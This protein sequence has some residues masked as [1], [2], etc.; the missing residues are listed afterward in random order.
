MIRV[1]I[2]D[3]SAVL[4][5]STKFILES[6]PELCV[7]GQASNGAEAIT[8]AAMLKPDVI[9]M[10]IRMPKVDGLEAIREIMAEHPTPIVVVTGVDLDRES[11]VSAQAT[12]L[13]AV[14][15]LK[16]PD[17]IASSDYKTF[18]ARLIRQVKSMSSVK[19]IHRARS[20]GSSS[21]G[22]LSGAGAQSDKMPTKT[23][24]VAI[25]SSTGGPAALYKILS[26]M[27]KD[28][29]LPIVIV[30]HISFGF[31]AGLASWLNDASPLQVRV[32][33]LGDRLEPGKAYIAPDDQHLVVDRFNK[34]GLSD[35]A[36]VGGHRPA[37]TALFQSVAQSFGSAAL[38]VILTG[39]GADG[40]LGMKTLC[41]AGAVTIAQDQASCVVFGMPKEAIAL[42]A[43]RHVV[44]LDNIAQKIQELV[45]V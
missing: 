18:A 40:A 16:R 22:K 25:G 44:P 4:R 1:L 35:S 19:V 26:R 23:E 2:V 34:I 10:D 14:S 20:L 13:G 6:D 42:G 43:I 45:V 29:A 11:D 21:T 15:F 7:V 9:T 3:D 27:P 33:K 17:G 30:Q 37:V 5:Q 36:P 8:Q 41:D 12:K 32:A 24:I 38:A 39:M 31:V 28:F